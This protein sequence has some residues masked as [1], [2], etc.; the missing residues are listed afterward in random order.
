MDSDQRCWLWSLF[1]VGCIIIAVTQGCEYTE[2]TMYELAVKAGTTPEEA[3]CAARIAPNFACRNTVVIQQ[4]QFT[5][6]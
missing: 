6:K 5:T 4:P 2:R 3:S 1:G